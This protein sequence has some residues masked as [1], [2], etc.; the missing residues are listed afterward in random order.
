MKGSDFFKKLNETLG[1][2]IPEETLTKLGEIELPDD[3]QTKHAEVFISKERAK[4]DESI[5]EHIV[6]ED[7][8]NTFR[9]VD[10]KIKAFLPF[11]GQ[12]HANVIN[13]TFETFKKL[14]MLTTAVGETVKNSKGK[15]SEDV[16]KVE[17][18]WAQKLTAK[19]EE[20]KKQ[21]SAQEAK[22]KEMQLEFVIKSKLLGYNIA[23]PFQNVKEH[24]TQMAI[25]DLKSK[26]YIYELENGT[27]AIRQEKD[28]VKRDVFEQGTET[29]LTLEKML[30][31]FVDPFVAKSNGKPDEKKDTSGNTQQ[32][33][34]STDPPKT[35]LE[36]MRAAAAQA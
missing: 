33:Q 2:Q 23:E 9:I 31:T 14:D 22:N 5:I 20:Y 11:V 30:D 24:L 17:E 26:P 19:E 12:E 3:M 1:V 8:K 28:G 16:R 13:N 18:E 32:K 4:H 35:H 6:K 21:L 25:I 27:V 29:K 7:R 15:V 10:E 36:R 34:V